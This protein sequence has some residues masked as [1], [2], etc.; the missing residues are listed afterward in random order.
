MP[1]AAEKWESELS[2]RRPKLLNFSGALLRSLTIGILSTTR[3]ILLF[4]WLTIQPYRH[5]RQKPTDHAP[6]TCNPD[7]ATGDLPTSR[8]LIVSEVSY[9]DL[10]LLLDC[11]QERTLI[12]DFEGEDA[13]LVWQGKGRAKDG[14]V[15]RR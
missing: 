15:W 14:A 5:K 3:S 6:E 12:V 4:R 10:A 1:T 2:R 7:P 11:R 9:C 8:P 13:V